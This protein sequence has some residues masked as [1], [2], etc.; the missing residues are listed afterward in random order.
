MRMKESRREC[1]EARCNHRC[2]RV[3]AAARARSSMVLHAIVAKTHAEDGGWRER[4]GIEA[5]TVN[6]AT[7]RIDRRSWA[8]R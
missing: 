5:R 1:R 4:P 6:G 2:R 3:A 8:N 7:R